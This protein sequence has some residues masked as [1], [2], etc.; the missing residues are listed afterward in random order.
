MAISPD[1]NQI[2]TG[3]QEKK[4]RIFDLQKPDAQPAVLSDTGST[5]HEG[6]VKSVVWF[7][8]NMVATASEDGTIK[9]A[10]EPSKNE[11]YLSDQF[12][13]GGMYVTDSWSTRQPSP[14]PLRRWNILRKLVGSSPPM[15]RLWRLFPLHLILHRPTV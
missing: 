9:Y 4:V 10:S 6:T 8:N 13:G 15:G 3:G 12:P 2:V 14:V 11:L 7:D 5:S 1:T